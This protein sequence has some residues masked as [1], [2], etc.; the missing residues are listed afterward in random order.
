MTFACGARSR[1]PCSAEVDAGADLADLLQEKVL[2]RARGLHQVA[3]R[4][5]RR[6]V[7][8]ELAAGADQGLEQLEVVAADAEGDQRGLGGERR[9]L[10]RGDVV[11]GLLR[12]GQVEGGGAGAAHVDELRLQG[13]GDE[14]GVVAARPQAPRLLLGLRH[15]G[16]R[17]VGVTERDVRREPL[18]GGLG[19]R[20]DGGSRVGAH[21]LGGVG[22]DRGCF[23]VATGEHGHGDERQ[24]GHDPTGG[25]ARNGTDGSHARCQPRR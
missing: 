16:C 23:V 15:P 7:E 14:V 11:A 12:A 5:S 24:R 20:L 10:R 13:G 1:M 2:P 8:A 4:R 17:G 9:E 19:G 6:V 3:A 22:G 18:V 21:A 25:H